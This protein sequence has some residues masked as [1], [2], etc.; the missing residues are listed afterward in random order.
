M[1]DTPVELSLA[2]IVDR[3]GCAVFANTDPNQVRAENRSV[4]ADALS[5]EA[6]RAS[7]R[8]FC[9]IGPLNAS[10]PDLVSFLANTKYRE[11]AQRSNA[12][13]VLC[14]QEEAD[15]LRA[16][17]GP[18]HRLLLVCKNPYAAFARL[19]QLY[20]RPHHGYEGQSDRSWIDATAAIGADVTAFPFVYIGPGAQ[21]G[22]G[23]V[24]YPGV[25]IGAGS[26]LGN[27]CIVYPNAVVREGCTLGQ[28]CIINPGAVVGGDGFGFAPD[29]DENVKIPHIGGVTIGEEVE[30]GSNASIDRGTIGDT[31]IGAQTKID[32]LVQVA[33]NVTIG[34]ACFLA[35]QS[36]VAGSATLSDR[37]TLGGQVA[38][39]GHVTLGKG[40][41]LL[42]KSGAS[43]SLDEPGLYNG[44][45]A[46]P[47]RE[48]LK[49]EAFIRRLV[50]QSK[51][52]NQASDNHKAGGES[53]S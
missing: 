26:V 16:H 41:T 25:F 24:L 23:C 30:V 49:R 6:I 20:F 22:K 47:N 15:L 39:T 13:A 11:D 35:A 28:G 18:G 21:I 29:G 48:F 19:S 31:R 45:P 46:V 51:R 38:V 50:D 44:V 3:I 12:G 7:T 1:A 36:G 9:G 5:T 4:A 27:D 52:R 42:G 2:E 8:R 37:V 34:K 14:S 53:N 43:K 10:G 17:Q 33:H 32:S 40:V